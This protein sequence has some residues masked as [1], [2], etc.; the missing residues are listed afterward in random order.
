MSPQ[1]EIQLIA[2]LISAACAIP[3]VFLVLRRMSM[4]ADS[5]TH[6]ILLGIILAF[7]AVQDLSSPVLIAG[8]ALMGV[9]TVWLTE[10][11]EKTKLVKGDSAIGIIFPLLFS[12]AVILICRY[13]GAVHLDTDSVLLGELAFAPFDRMVAGGYDI[14]AKSIY[15]SGGLLLANAILV[16]LFFKELKLVTFDPV[17]AAVLGFSP[18]IVHYALMTMV[19]LTAVVAFEAVG[20]VLVVAFMI[21]P[22]VTA[23]LLTDDLHTM[24]LLS[25]AFG[26]GSGLFGYRIAAFRDVSI[27][28][29]MAV[30]VGLLFVVVFLFSPVRGLIG[31]LVRK[32]LQKRVFM[33]DMVLLYLYQYNAGVPIEQIRR[34]F[35]W[36]QAKLLGV[37]SGLRREQLILSTAEAV[38]MTARG[39]QQGEKTE[40]ALFKTLYQSTAL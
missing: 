15:L 18:V 30:A 10:L 14:G 24:L 5:I 21:G 37:L 4:M 22:P 17:L 25:V 3:G 34:H 11:V 23:Y 32:K 35:G 40:Q 16:L 33:K 31:I 26:A 39:K 20:S 13:T 36:P 12:I 6:T 19:S 7:F 28:G 2:V 29:S 9:F 8:A 1:F 38:V 27:A